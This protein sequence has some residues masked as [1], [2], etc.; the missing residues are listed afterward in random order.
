MSIES[1]NDGIR[2]SSVAKREAIVAA[3]ARAFF[4]QG[5]EG[6]SIEAIAANAGV[7]KVTVY[8][9]FGGKPGLLSAAVEAECASMGQYLQFDGPIEGTIR[10][11]LTALGH[12]FAAFLSR[13]EIVNFD[14]RIASET[15][16]DPEI[17]ETFLNAG[18]R[19]MHAMLAGLMA[20]ADEAGE[21]KIDD[22]YLA[23]EQFV[24]MCK[25]FGDPERRFSAPNDAERNLVRITGA[26]DTFLRAYSTEK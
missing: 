14:R 12:A 24:S 4:E 7:S 13:P 3:A 23:A 26:V 25:G 5:Y 8:K 1:E 21:L 6:A 2:P 18:P 17:G 20:Q 19:K 15:S 22:P 11:R 9:H 16:R 10:Q